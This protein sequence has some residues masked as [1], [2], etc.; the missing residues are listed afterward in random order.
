CA[1]PIRE[2]PHGFQRVSPG[3]SGR[4]AACTGARI[5]RSTHRFPRGS[6]REPRMFERTRLCRGLMLAFG[7]GLALAAL[8]AMAQQQ[9]ERVEITGSSIK[10]VESETALP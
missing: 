7:G 6:W 5:H 4:P 1:L 2:F 3:R 9:L 10:R 8:P